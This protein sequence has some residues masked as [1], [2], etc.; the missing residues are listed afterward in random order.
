MTGWACQVWT[1]DLGEWGLRPLARYH[2]CRGVGDSLVFKREPFWSSSELR[3][4]CRKSLPS[5]S[6]R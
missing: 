2:V 4:A 3:V 6:C 5:H 1:D